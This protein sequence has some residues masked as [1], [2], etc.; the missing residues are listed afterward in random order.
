LPLID[1]E[2]NEAEAIAPEPETTEAAIE[3]VEGEE[4]PPGNG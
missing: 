4:P 2:T 1:P 3:A